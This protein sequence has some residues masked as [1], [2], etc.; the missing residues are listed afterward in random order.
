MSHTDSHNILIVEDDAAIRD[1]LKEILED[2][3]YR[4]SGA[5]NGQEA[6]DLLRGHSRPCV[7]LLDLM[8][9]VM[10]G[11]QF[12]AAQRQ[13]PALAPI[14]TVVISADGNVAEKAAAI[15]AADFLTKPIQLN[16]LLETIERYC[17]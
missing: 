11:W 6:I 2:E 4:V 17:A 14:P 12:R 15:E 1:A 8:M 10:N 13:D 16:R 5:A 7:I 3:G 9:P